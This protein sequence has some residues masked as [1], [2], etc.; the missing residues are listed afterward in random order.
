MRARNNDLTQLQASEIAG[1]SDRSAR[2][3]ESERH[4]PSRGQP[5]GRKPDPLAE[6]WESV[7]KPKLESDP[8]L[9]P[10]TL[11]EFLVETYPQ[12]YEDDKGVAHENGGIESPHGHFKRRLSQVLYLRESCD[13]ETVSAYQ[14]FSDQEV[15]KLNARCSVKFAQ[16]Q[17]HLQA[18]PNTAIATT[19]G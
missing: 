14:Q 7:L 12:Q 17:P 16:E 19:K 18:L 2:R 13:F 8:R 10:R 15:A 5:R 6:V 4:Q 1:F 9:K 3:V 11:Y